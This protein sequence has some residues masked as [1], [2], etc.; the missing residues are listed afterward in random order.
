MTKL[1]LFHVVERKMYHA[2]QTFKF[3]VKFDIWFNE[4]T[5]AQTFSS[6]I[7]FDCEGNALSDAFYRIEMELLVFKLCPIFLG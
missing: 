5:I 1:K 3:D 6:Y 2:R 4:D 7:Q